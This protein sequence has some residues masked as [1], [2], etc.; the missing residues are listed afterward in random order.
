MS[1]QQH[2]HTPQYKQGFPRKPP[3][4]NTSY[5]HPQ[6]A[7]IKPYKPLIYGPNTMCLYQH[8]RAYRGLN[9]PASMEAA[10]R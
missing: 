9:G 5:L 3:Y 2:R 6:K 7:P 1:A 10:I 4:Y 8:K